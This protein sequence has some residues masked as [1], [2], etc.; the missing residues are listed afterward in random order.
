MNELVDIESRLCHWQMALS[1]AE[2]AVRVARAQV[3]IC[4]AMKNKLSETVQIVLLHG[5]ENE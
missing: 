5:G 1:T 3:E 4:Q 2:N